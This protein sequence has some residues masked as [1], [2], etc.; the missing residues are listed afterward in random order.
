MSL[1]SAWGRPFDSFAAPRP[2]RDPIDDAAR[3]TTTRG[4]TD[5][6]RIPR[7]LHPRGTPFAGPRLRPR[8][9]RAVCPQRRRAGAGGRTR[10]RGGGTLAVGAGVGGHRPGGWPRAARQGAA[11]DLA[12]G[13]GAR[14]R[15]RPRSHT[16]L[17]AGARTRTARDGHHVR[18]R[19]GPRRVDAQGQP[20]H[21][22][23][24]AVQR[25]GRGRA[26]RRGADAGPAAG[27]AAGMRQAFPGTR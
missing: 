9:R 15:R 22:R 5:A 4:A 25:S 24:V 12:G 3:Q 8:R 6:G 17:C 2:F 19:A 20:G 16:A 18:L 14:S 11:D 21:R 27:R 1:G 23:S 13:R 7:P 26:P 10:A